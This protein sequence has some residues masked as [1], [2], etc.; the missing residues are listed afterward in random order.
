[1][2]TGLFR[3]PQ[4]CGK[5]NWDT[6]KKKV[7]NGFDVMVANGDKITQQEEG[8]VPFNVP[9]AAAAHVAVFVPHLMLL[10]QYA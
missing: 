9:A 1:M 4:F 6:K 10:V 3:H 7:K 5:K 2:E 8:L